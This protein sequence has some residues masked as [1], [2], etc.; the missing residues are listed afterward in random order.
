[1]F[2]RAIARTPSNNFADGITTA[3]LGA[4]D[5]PKALHQ[6]AAYVRA[7]ESCGLQ[8]TTLDPD[9]AHPDSTFVEDTA[10]IFGDKAVLAR[11]GAA[12]RVGEVEGIRAAIEA[13]IR[14]IFEITP[15]GTL[16]GGDICEAGEHFFIGIS[17][18]TNEEGG[19]QLARLLTAAGYSSSF[20]DI[21]ALRGILHLKSGLAHLGDRDLV[22]WPEL[23]AFEQFRGYNHIYVSPDDRYAAN[24]V[25]VNNRI[26]IAEGF[27]QFNGQIERAGYQPL[28]LD[29]S[30]FRKMDGGLSCLSLRF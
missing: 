20:V 19:R 9:P 14:T 25:R 5:Y 3:G 23:A 13:Q 18:R 7:L 17:Q 30:E 26:L 24:C 15:P 10:V 6:H 29:V 27:S 22:L 8:V 4:A 21:R 2:T 11:P 1:V 16:D 12:S 28:A